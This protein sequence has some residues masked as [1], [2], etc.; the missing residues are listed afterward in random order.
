MFS[1]FIELG[2]FTHVNLI[3]SDVATLIFSCVSSQELS[4]EDRQKKEELELLVQRAQDQQMIHLK[5]LKDFKVYMWVEL[6]CIIEYE[7]T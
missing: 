7:M 6:N 4:E 5:N 3:H 2:T 1:I